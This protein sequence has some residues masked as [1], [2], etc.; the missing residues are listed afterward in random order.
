MIRFHQE[1]KENSQALL[2]WRSFRIQLF[3]EGTVIGLLAG[4]IVVLFRFALENAEALRKLIYGFL[5]EEALGFSALWFGIL[6]VIAYL[7]GYMMK[8]EPLASGSGIPQVK[9]AILGFFKLNW[10]RILLVKFI[11]GVLAIG[12]GLSLGREGPSIQI[13]AVIGQG[14][15]RN[16]GKTRLEERYL[17]TSGACAGLAAAFNAPLAGVFFALE[18]LHKSFSPAVLMSAIAASLTADFVVRFFYGQQPFWHLANVPVLPFT[19]YGYLVLLGLITGILGVCFN[20]VLVQSLELFSHQKLLPKNME[21][22]LPLVVGGG[23][24]FILPEILG[25]GNS[26][27]DIIALGHLGV[28]MLI[29]LLVGKFFFTMLSYGSGVPGGIFL[30][31]LVI[32]A[33]IGG[34]FSKILLVWGLNPDYQTTFM[35]LAMAAYFT[36]IVKAPITGSILVTEMTGSFDHLFGMITISMIAYIVADAV[37]SK[38]VYELLLNRSLQQKR[39]ELLSGRAKKRAIIEMV[40]S[41]NSQ[42]EGKKIKAVPWPDSCLLICIRRGEKEIVPHGD[43]KLIAGDYLYLSTESEDITQIHY[44]KS[45]ASEWNQ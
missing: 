41:M 27:I 24:G 26:L 5:H 3:M 35:I 45:L 33:L 12:A 34:A 44:I 40:V 39:P 28:T 6:V 36:A 38:P 19:Y 32:G 7:L 25:G 29:I 13:G 37:Q 1:M 11:G 14:F 20:K 15:S 22:A 21:A 18:E 23:L 42:L 43:T 17:M 9:G 8:I 16:L 10:L 30:P 4:F 31:M 2:G